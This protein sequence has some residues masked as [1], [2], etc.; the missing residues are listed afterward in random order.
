MRCRLKE[1]LEERGI[2][3]KW[4][5]ERVGMSQSAINRLVNGKSSPLLE[6]AIRIAKV[7]E[8]RV[9]DIWDIDE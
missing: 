5:Q 2:K 8:L 6:D 7:L 9:E 3:Q 1:I 4:L